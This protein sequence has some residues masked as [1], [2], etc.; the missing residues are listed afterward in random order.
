MS[1][2]LVVDNTRGGALSVHDVA[3]RWGCSDRHVRSLIADGRL[4][5]FRLGHK[6]IRVPMSA[7]E[8]FERCQ[9]PTCESSPSAAV[10]RRVHRR[11]KAS[12]SLPWD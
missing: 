2:R 12:S 4:Q 6:L 5:S 10:R 3:V 9:L 8:E 7:V 11:R 1:V